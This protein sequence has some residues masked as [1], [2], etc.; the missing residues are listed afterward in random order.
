MAIY[1]LSGKI[2]S[3]SQGRSL[4]ASAAYRSGEKLFDAR[5]NKDQ[6]Y[7]QKQHV[8]HKE[9]LLPEQAPSWMAERETLWNA[10]EAAEKRK[11]AQLAREFTISLPQ[12]LSLESNILLA[13]EFAQR[14]F[15]DRGMV[16]DVCI[17]TEKAKDGSLQP[18]AH[19][20]LTLR[21]VTQEGFGKKARAWNDK[22]LLLHW[23]E[24]WAEYANHALA[25]EGF[26]KT[27]D[28]RTLEAQGITL[29]P[30]HKIG[31]SVAKERLARAQDHERI[32]RE[33]G[34]RLLKDPEIA[35]N[36]LTQAQSTFTHQDLARFVSRHTIDAEQFSLVYDTVKTH[37]SLVFLGID[38][39]QRERFTTKTMLS[40]ESRMMDK[41]LLLSE[42]HT[43]AV[44][45]S[46]Q[47]ATLTQCHL[48]PEQQ[49][50]F[51][52]LMAPSAL[53]CIVGFAGTGKSY[54]L[55]AA[56]AAWEAQGYQVQ[57]VT[58]SG[59]AAESLEKSS[60]I[61]SRTFASRCYYWEKGEQL[62]G[63]QTILVVDEAG[64]LASRHMGR[65]LEEAH[66][67]GAKVVLVGDPAQLQAIEAGAAFRAIAERLSYVELT[68][69]QRQQDLGQQAATKAFATGKTEEGLGYYL[70]QGV[71]YTLPTHEQA[72]IALVEAWQAARHSAPSKTQLMLAYHRAD[73][74]DLNTMA[75][76][77]RK[78][79]GELTQ[80]LLFHT[81]RGERVFAIHERV[82]F[83]KNDRALGVVNGSLG[84]IEKINDDTLTVRLDSLLTTKDPSSSITFTLERYNALDYGYAATIHKSQG[85]TVDKSYVLASKALDAQATYVAMSRHREA[86]NVFYGKDTFLSSD[87]LLQTLSRERLKDVSLDYVNNTL[88][89]TRFSE[90]RGIER[91]D[92]IPNP[93]EVSLKQRALTAKAQRQARQQRLSEFSASATLNRASKSNI[94]LTGRTKDDL[95]AFKRRFE[96]RHPER[97]HQLREAILPSL[98]K[99]ALRYE[100]DIQR[101][102]ASLEKGGRTKMLAQTRLEAL[103]YK[104]AQD[105]ALMHYWRERREALAD[106]L[107]A[108][109]QDYCRKRDLERE[110]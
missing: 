38:E 45:E 4:V 57:G 65:L 46:F 91:H 97:A 105:K 70:Q 58:L 39:A 71:V 110:L 40:L 54:L 64:M 34:E 87:A 102:E 88:V 26:D 44:R 30:Q 81:E 100:A 67:G 8:V 29:E 16:A 52:H 72:K 84:T 103:S 13:R 48:T 25:R 41:A 99:K 6:D 59:I 101:L 69:I 79:Q 107:E 27:I 85:V 78:A 73:V 43:H 94:Q 12:E 60:G 96:A 90:V 15:V 42:C 77:Q 56:K 55:G 92:K 75:R 104:L 22:S 106:N 109:A 14:A 62:L 76:A 36:A 9:I 33:N 24:T 86:V 17:H 68:T 61:P 80:E 63:K 74:A 82:Y 49:T 10:V 66:R 47:K 28:H 5:Y 32:A 98:E 7:T 19:I 2:I 20:L 1:H 50:A 35:L 11:D 53:R 95:A 83:L 31:A 51:E 93:P 18:H 108:Y 21:E 3:R 89:K 23:R 37:E